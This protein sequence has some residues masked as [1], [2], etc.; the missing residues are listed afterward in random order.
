[1]EKTSENVN[2][3]K[4]L[5]ED[6]EMDRKMAERLERDYK[7]Q[8]GLDALTLAR[9]NTELEEVRMIHQK[10][11]EAAA[12]ADKA[13]QAATDR[14]DETNEAPTNAK[15]AKEALT[16][17]PAKRRPTLTLPTRKG[18]KRKTQKTP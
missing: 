3:E 13:K 1:M 12:E 5:I 17:P 15:A 14:L 8:V 10:L 4:Q 11:V 9:A 16:R 6:K 7:P 2:A 18:R